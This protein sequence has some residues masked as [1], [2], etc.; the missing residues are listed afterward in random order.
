MTLLAAFLALT[1]P[2]R[3]VFAQKRTWQRAQRQALGALLVLGR[4]TLSRILR[5]NGREQR[6]LVRRILPAFARGLG[7]AVAE[8]LVVQP[9][10]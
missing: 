10:G 5:T 8:N 9:C 3:S 4:A 7:A 2:W 1:G 6:G